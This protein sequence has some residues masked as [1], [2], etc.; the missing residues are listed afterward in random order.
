MLFASLTDATSAERLCK[1]PPTTALQ[2]DV[3]AVTATVVVI[4]TVA[5]VLAPLDATLIAATTAT[6]AVTTAAM[7]AVTTV[8]TAVMTAVTIVVGMIGATTVTSRARIAAGRRAVKMTVSL[9][10]TEAIA[11]IVEA[12]VIVAT[13]C[14]SLCPRSYHSCRDFVLSL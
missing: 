4:T 14:F 8:T 12:N 2:V 9:K 7:T 5:T 13:N 6:T 10:M 11:M 3:T 1:W